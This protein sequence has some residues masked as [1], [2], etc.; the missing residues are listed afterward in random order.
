MNDELKAIRVTHHQRYCAVLRARTEERDAAQVR[1]LHVAP[2]KKLEGTL[3]AVREINSHGRS[4]LRENADQWRVAGFHLRTRAV[5]Q[6]QYLEHGR[7]GRLFGRRAAAWQAHEHQQ[8]RP[9]KK[10]ASHGAGTRRIETRLASLTV[11]AGVGSQA[12]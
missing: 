9:R 12:T 7:Y 5:R 2:M 11:R 4:S 10:P 1:E 6:H 8:Q 3:I